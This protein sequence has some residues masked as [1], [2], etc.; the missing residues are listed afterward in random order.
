MNSNKPPKGDAGHAPRRTWMKLDNAAKIYPAI[1]S[2]RSPAMF[3]FTMELTEEI[4][5]ALLKTALERTLKRLPSFSQ[6]LRGGL[7]WYYFEQ[8]DGLPSISTD[9]PYPCAY[10]NTKN[11]NNF[12]LRVFHFNCTIAV[13]FFHVLTDGMGAATFMKTLVAEYLRLKYNMFIP[14][15]QGV[16]D[17]SESQ[18]PYEI[19]D[20]FLANARAVTKSRKEPHAYHFKMEREPVGVLHTTAGLMSVAEVHAKAKEFSATINEFLTSV[21]LMTVYELQQ[22][23]TRASQRKKPVRVCVPI[24]L[25]RFYSSRT[26]RN[27]TSYVNVGIDPCLGQYTLPEVVEIVRHSMALE[28]N[29]KSLNVKLSTNVSA[30]GNKA[31]R[32]I[33]LFIKNPIMKLVYMMIAD[34]FN[35]TTLTNMGVFKLPDEMVSQVKK[36]NA[37][38]GPG[39]N[40]VACSCLSYNGT[41]MFNFSRT[42][43]QPTVEREFFKKLVQL[44]IH[45]KVESNQR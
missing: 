35:T 28:A 13:E 43:I 24:N 45:I 40:P 22:Q 16:L 17:C 14:F 42:A 1:R 20:S 29:E 27:F 25:R 32:G 44:G 26:L 8:Q 2:K 36:V 4:D 7:F 12:L 37:I 18:K 10:L 19:E 34:T 9:C 6:R 39:N 5:E 15:T 3:R 30:E 33:P 38:L 23:D 11:N 21:L 31:V 41:L